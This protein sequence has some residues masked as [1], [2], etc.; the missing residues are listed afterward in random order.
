MKPIKIGI[1]GTRHNP[2]LYEEIADM[3]LR[4][5]ILWAVRE[6]GRDVGREE[7]IEKGKEDSLAQTAKLML[8]N[9]EPI[10][11]IMLY[12]GLAKADIEKLVSWAVLGEAFLG[13]DDNDDMWAAMNR[14]L[15]FFLILC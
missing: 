6:E 1:G 4:E 12:T 10:D 9:N 8:A 13:F 7:G 5:H 14:R 2:V 15:Y 3:E 11:K